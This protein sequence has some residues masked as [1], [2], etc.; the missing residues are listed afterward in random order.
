MRF[1][2]FIKL[3]IP[4]GILALKDKIKR[5][6]EGIPF[7][8][9]NLR[10]I[11]KAPPVYYFTEK[12][13]LHEENDVLQIY[14]EDY[15]YPLYIRNKTSDVEIYREILDRHV[16]DFSVKDEPKYIIDAGANIGMA[17]IFF[18]KKYRN[19]KIIAIEPEVENFKLYKA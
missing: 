16:Y 2:N 11:F 15:E 8:D 10:D 12:S 17:S 18:A 13:I 4:Y 9:I 5:V 6:S 7:M 14:R 3:F 19:A 1:K